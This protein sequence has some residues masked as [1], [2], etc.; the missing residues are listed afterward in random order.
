M[1][2]HIVYKSTG[3]I[4][5]CINV[6]TYT[7]KEGEIVIAGTANPDTNYISNGQVCT[8]TPEEIAAKRNI[9]YGYAWKMPE[10]QVVQVI[11][12]KELGEYRARQ[13]R[14]K[15]NSLLKASDWTMVSDAPTD[16]TAWGVYRQA[17][18]DI[19]QQTGFP[20]NIDWPELPV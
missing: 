9:Q 1:I 14:T 19:P 18:R 11:S 17:L 6:A 2:D 7:P 13:A 3:E 15:R 5:A 20:Q 4:L 10:R 8:Y 12:D 16:K